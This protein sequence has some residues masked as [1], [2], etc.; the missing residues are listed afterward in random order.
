V[1]GP[2]VHVHVFREATNRIRPPKTADQLR[3]RADGLRVHFL[4]RLCTA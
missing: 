3:L 2:S 1:D 4:A